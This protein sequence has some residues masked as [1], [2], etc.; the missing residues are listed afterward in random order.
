M[1]TQTAWLNGEWQP[2]EAARVSPL[3]RGFLFGD[4]V[5]EVIPVYNRRVF[6]FEPHLQRLRHSLEATGIPNP[7]TD[8]EWEALC[9][10]LVERHPWT[11]QYLYIQ[12]TRGVQAKRDHLPQSCLVPTVFAY[13]SELKPIDEAV[14]QRGVRCITTQ[15]IRWQRC[16]IKAITLLA[17]VMMKLEAQRAGAD[18]AILIRNGMV[19]EGTASNVMIVEGQSLVTPPLD[20]HLLGGI[21]RQILLSCA[22]AIGLLPVEEPISI[23]RLYQADE[24]WLTSSTKEALPVV[25]LDE[26]PVGDGTPGPVWQAMRSHYQQEKQRLVQQRGDAS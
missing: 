14:L 17:N 25:E 7:H 20:H 6:A 21:T 23:Q 15:D 3:D 24:I 16:D 5:Y 4:G 2:L 22:P 9:T 12:V 13:T 19:S 1:S 10:G 18:D 26:R 11:N 8:E